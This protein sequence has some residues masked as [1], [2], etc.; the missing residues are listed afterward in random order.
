[1]RWLDVSLVG[2]LVPLCVLLSRLVTDRCRIHSSSVCAIVFL[3]HDACA[4]SL[5]Y[6]RDGMNHPSSRKKSQG[7]RTKRRSCEDIRRRKN[8]DDS[9]LSLEE[10]Q[11]VHRDRD[12]VVVDNRRLI[13]RRSNPPLS[14]LPCYTR[15]QRPRHQ[16]KPTELGCGI[17]VFVLLWGETERLSR[18]Q[19]RCRPGHGNDEGG[20][21]SR[22]WRT[23]LPTAPTLLL[24]SSLAIKVKNNMYR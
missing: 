23:L 19:L 7:R 3:S 2:L 14:S 5:T 11:S 8:P 1:M 18:Q 12:I 22:T 21:P 4:L 15:Q 13:N 6:T 17:F 10:V 9:S 16:D 24:L 20:R